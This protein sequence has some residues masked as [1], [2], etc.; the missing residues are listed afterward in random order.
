M[1]DH[2]DRTPAG[3]EPQRSS[4][5]PTREEQREQGHGI[6]EFH[7][8]RGGDQPPGHQRPRRSRTPTDPDEGGQDQGGRCQLP[9]IMPSH[10]SGMSSGIFQPKLYC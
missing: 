5:A 6:R 8:G 7:G 9:S 2:E 3:E 4:N 1:Q 10:P